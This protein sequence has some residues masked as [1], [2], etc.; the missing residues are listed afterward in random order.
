VDDFIAFDDGVLVILCGEAALRQE[1]AETAVLRIRLKCSVL[2]GAFVKFDGAA[3]A[4]LVVAVN[5]DDGGS[6][7]IGPVGLH[8]HAADPG[9]LLLAVWAVRDGGVADLGA[10]GCISGVP[11]CCFGIGQQFD[12]FVRHGA[13]CVLRVFSG[14]GAEGADPGYIEVI[15]VKQFS[16]VVGRVGSVVAGVFD[17]AFGH[18]DK[19]G[20]P[21][22]I[23]VG[24]DVVVDERVD[25][26]GN[27]VVVG[28]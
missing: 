18:E 22:I 10:V 5:G 12:E 25:E 7:L 26:V 27:Y 1:I 21:F 2:D 23:R 6:V 11:G 4:R 17:E 3:D 28:L 13:Q 15:P 19:G 16:V 24:V 20:D 8:V 14:L 9:R